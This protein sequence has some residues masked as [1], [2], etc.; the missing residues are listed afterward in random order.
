MIAKQ[1]KGRG[2]RGTVNYVL[3]KEGGKLIGGNMLGETPRELS[4]EFAESRK[5]RPNLERAVYHAS[6]SLPVGEK[7]S[8]EKWATV[9]EQYVHKMGFE[10]SQYMVARHND[11]EHDHIHIIASRIGLDGGYV[12]ESNDY[13]RSEEIVRG[14]EREH[15]LTRVTPSHEV[16]KR[17]LTRG[18]LEMAG[19][20]I[21]SIKL[22][23]QG[24]VDAAITDKPTMSQFFERM[25]AAGAKV[26]PNIAKTGHVS[27]ISFMLGNEQM[28]GSDLGRGYTWSGLQKRGVDYEQERDGETIS[29]RSERAEARESERDDRDLEQGG[30]KESGTPD[31]Q[32]R[33][34]SRSD[35]EGYG[36][37]E[38]DDGGTYGDSEDDHEGSQ[39]RDGASEIG[40]AENRESGR[41]D[42]SQDLD[43]DDS[44]RVPHI[45]DRSQQ[46]RILASVLRN[47]S[48]G[49]S[50][51][52]KFQES[53]S[54][55]ERGKAAGILKALGLGSEEVDESVRKPFDEPSSTFAD[56][57]K[58]K[59]QKKKDPFS[60]DIFTEEKTTPPDKGRGRS[61]DNGPD[62]D[63]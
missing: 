15:G 33:G 23:L 56:K 27:G 29:R 54:E 53:V 40:G 38:S 24:L 35:G 44:S 62:F 42:D 46:L 31:G 14:L 16:E 10:K 3:E 4:A 47:S 63:F 50:G 11:T 28:K 13:K 2:F 30:L 8:D 55:S 52:E 22:Q 17:A 26:I 7:L 19:Q 34:F 9:A 48:G 36:L 60:F 18:E 45:R 5:L 6:L 39:R 25:D 37:D 41:E 21:A 20:G 43:H 32:D 58:E 12:S 1:T 49:G 51:G 61:V 59:P 57:L